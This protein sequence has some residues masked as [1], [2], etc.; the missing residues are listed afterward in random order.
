M[1]LERAHD[2]DDDDDDDHDQSRCEKE[3]TR[4]RATLIDLAKPAGR[5]SCQKT[6][7]LPAAGLDMD[8]RTGCEWQRL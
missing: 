8:K 5:P 2:Q 3:Q 4:A 7:T 6:T 1:A